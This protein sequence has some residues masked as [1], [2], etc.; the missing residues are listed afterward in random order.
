MCDIDLNVC[1]TFNVV[2]Q[3]FVSGPGLACRV[4]P[5][6]IEDNSVM[7]W[8]YLDGPL[9]G[10]VRF[11]NE[12]LMECDIVDTLVEKVSRGHY[13]TLILEVEVSNDGDT[14]SSGIFLTLYNSTCHTCPHGALPLMPTIC[15]DRSDVCR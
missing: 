11:I 13:D 6:V 4:R 10:E 15:T 5:V 14:W 8:K 3:D 1:S 2:G 12:R 9:I 7:N